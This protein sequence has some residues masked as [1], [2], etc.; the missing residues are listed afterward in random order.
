M[1]ENSSQP[2]FYASEAHWEV[3]SANVQWFIVDII[4][5]WFY[6]LVSDI[7]HARFLVSNMQYIYQKWSD[8]CIND[9]YHTNNVQLYG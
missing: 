3:F 1:I 9:T 4:G 6:M 8:I 5:I 7:V 2:L